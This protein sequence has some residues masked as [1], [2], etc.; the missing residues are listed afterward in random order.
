MS[1]KNLPYN[2]DAQKVLKAFAD[3]LAPKVIP[4]DIEKEKD[5]D[6]QETDAPFV[7]PMDI[8]FAHR[9]RM[10]YPTF[11]TADQLAEKTG[12]PVAKVKKILKS[13][14]TDNFRDSLRFL[15][16]NVLLGVYRSS[17]DGNAQAA[18][19]WLQYVEEWEEKSKTSGD[20]SGTLTLKVEREIVG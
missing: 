19:L 5:E 17:Q 14:N 8:P 3:L 18:K 15:T 4:V 16:P 2:P 20:L 9:Y 10:D 13:I 1:P 12:F 7:R 11:P 6:G